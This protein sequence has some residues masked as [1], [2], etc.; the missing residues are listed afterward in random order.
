MRVVLVGGKSPAA[1]GLRISLVRRADGE[2]R[3]AD[4]PSVNFWLKDSTDW[5]FLTVGWSHQHSSFLTRRHLITT[6]LRLRG[7]VHIGHLGRLH[8]E[9]LRV[10]LVDLQDKRRARTEGLS[11]TSEM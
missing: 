3:P 1:V 4:A 11:M 8:V 5:Y 10:V 9:Q 7:Q 2:T 6:R